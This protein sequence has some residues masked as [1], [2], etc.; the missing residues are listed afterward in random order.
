V[1]GHAKR[2]KGGLL[3]MEQAYSPLCASP[4]IANLHR[5][6]AISKPPRVDGG[7]A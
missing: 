4:A 3:I 5:L 6:E 7:G 1:R 2:T